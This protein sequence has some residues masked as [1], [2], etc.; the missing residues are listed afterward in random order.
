ME[1]LK[2]T[3]PLAWVG[4]MNNIKIRAEEIVFNELIYI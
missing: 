2:N 3:D 4:A 1:D